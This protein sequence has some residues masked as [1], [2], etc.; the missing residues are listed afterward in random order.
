MISGLSQ[1]KMDVETPLC[2]TARLYP[3][4]ERRGHAPFGTTRNI[5]SELAFII[6]HSAFG[7]Q[8]SRYELHPEICF[9]GF[10]EEVGRRDRKRFTSVEST[11]QVR[12]QQFVMGPGRHARP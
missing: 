2:I 1:R 3:R 11:L 8:Y 12:T 4:R 7:L 6:L 10:A 9:R 5:I